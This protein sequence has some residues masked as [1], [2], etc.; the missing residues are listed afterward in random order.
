[1]STIKSSSENLTLNADGAGN[2][3]VIQSNGATTATITADGV[4]VTGT[5]TANG[6][7]SGTAKFSTTL[8]SGGVGIDA[9]SGSNTDTFTD[10]DAPDVSATDGDITYRLGRS[11]TQGSSDNSRLVMYAHNGTN[12]EAFVADS[13]GQVSFNSGY[14]SAA[15]VYGVRA[16]VNFDGIGTVAIRESGN[17]SSITDL[18]VGKF[19]VNFSTNMP[20]VNYAPILATNYND[21]GARVYTDVFTL[22]VGSFEISVRS[23]ANAVRLDPEGSFAA[24]I[25]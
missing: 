7:S 23:A 20:D 15:P 24:V 13:A 19:R 4:D 10:F 17:V 25:R 2:D 11:T 9:S 22:A 21:A 18:D 12:T 14:G 6:S 8:S 1:M 16:W 3:V 5:I